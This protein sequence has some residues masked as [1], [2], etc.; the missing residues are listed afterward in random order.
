MKVF[1]Y[2]IP[3]DDLFAL[4]L[5]VKARVLTVQEQH[6]EPQMWVLVDE[7]STKETR[8]FRLA[9]TGH[10]IDDNPEAL[11]YIGTFQL[12]G[13]SFIGHLFEIKQ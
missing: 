5:P 3:L 6:G 9:G 12:G 2:Q 4:D 7:D 1:K 11:D 10:N 8:N 13:G